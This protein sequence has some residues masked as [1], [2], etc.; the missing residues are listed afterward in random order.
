MELMEGVERKEEERT[1]KEG[2]GRRGEERNNK[3]ERQVLYRF[4]F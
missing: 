2:S 3:G 1:E 4:Q